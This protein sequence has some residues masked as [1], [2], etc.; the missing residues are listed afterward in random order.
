M[1]IKE[2]KKFN[3]R[4]YDREHYRRNRKAILRKTQKRRREYY[5]KNKESVRLQQREYMRK[6][7]EKTNKRRKDYREKNPE[8]ARKYYNKYCRLNPE[9][10]K[11]KSLA[12]KIPLKSSCEICGD[13]DNL[14]RHHWRYDKPFLINTLCSTRHSVQHL[15]KF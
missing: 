14:Q 15:K 4:E 1:K 10:R 3:K 12:R 13:K 2:K 11:A 8:N 9:K 7:K 5:H 6:N